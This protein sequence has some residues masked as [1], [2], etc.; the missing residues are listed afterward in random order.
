MLSAY[1]MHRP[2][3][4]KMVRF[5]FCALHHFSLLTTCC[6]FQPVKMSAKDDHYGPIKSKCKKL[7]KNS[8]YRKLKADDEDEYSNP[9]WAALIMQVHYALFQLVIYV[10]LGF[11]VKHTTVVFY[12]KGVLQTSCRPFLSQVMPTDPPGLHTSAA[13]VAWVETK[14]CCILEGNWNFRNLS[15]EWDKVTKPHTQTLTQT[16]TH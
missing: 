7:L 11:G 4:K 14:L 2:E 3:N 16:L 5:F 9:E 12:T 6:L 10:H 13:C 8:S 1:G 15:E